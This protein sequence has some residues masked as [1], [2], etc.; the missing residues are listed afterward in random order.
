MKVMALGVHN[1]TE[2]VI[3]G[4]RLGLLSPVAPPRGHERAAAG[5]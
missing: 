2:A 3:T 4:I 1:R 5:G